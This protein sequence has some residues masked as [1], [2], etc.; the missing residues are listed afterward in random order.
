M[1]QDSD[2]ATIKAST[3]LAEF[4]DVV[5]HHATIGTSAAWSLAAPATLGQDI[6]GE[7]T[8]FPRP[9]ERV[10]HPHWRLDAPDVRDPK[11]GLSHSKSRQLP[12][13]SM[14]PP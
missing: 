14:D 5:A 13:H 4:H 3:A 12:G 7:G 1:A 11:S 9:I 2:V 6:L 10:V 8:P